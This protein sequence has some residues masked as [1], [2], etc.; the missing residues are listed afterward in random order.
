MLAVLALVAFVIA[1]I[2]KLI[3]KDPQAQIWLIIA[4][5]ILVSAHCLW[6]W[7]PWRNRA[8]AP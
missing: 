2:L 3:A 6:G 8:G 5:G 1:A 4:G 7:T